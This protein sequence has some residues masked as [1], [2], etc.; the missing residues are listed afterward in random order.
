VQIHLNLKPVFD[1]RAVASTRHHNR[2]ILALLNAMKYSIRPRAAHC[3][4][5]PAAETGIVNEIF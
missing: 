2:A 1:L 5:L 4:Y 3:L